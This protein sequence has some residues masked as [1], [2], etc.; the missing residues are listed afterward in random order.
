MYLIGDV[1]VSDAVADEQFACN[2]TACKGACCWEGDYGS[3]LETEEIATLERIYPLIA[4]RLTPA[5]RAAVETQGTSVYTP[6][7]GD[8]ATPLV[9]NGPCAYMTLDR[10]GMAHCAIEKAFYA[11]EIDYHKPISCHLYPIRVARSART[12]FEA[13]NY[14]EWDICSAA[15][16]K[17]ARERIAVYE[18]AKA[19]LVRK[20][21]EAWWEELD[22]AVGEIKKTGTQSA[23]GPEINT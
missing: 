9:N 15:C 20:Y 2:L 4:D 14:D 8:Y 6:D 22:R 16:T 5:G 21:G 13:L 7:T 11:G 3:P 23:T 17:G 10:N 18:F 1:L 19:A 12:D